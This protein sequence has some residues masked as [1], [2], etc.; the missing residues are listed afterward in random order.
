[1]GY[2]GLVSQWGATAVGG[3]LVSSGMW[4]IRLATG[5]A[6]WGYGGWGVL[7]LTGVVVIDGITDMWEES[8]DAA[9][10]IENLVQPRNDAVE[11][12]INENNK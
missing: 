2:D 1:M 9:N 5:V 11:R 3:P 7:I 4:G 8:G 10:A 6:A 12:E